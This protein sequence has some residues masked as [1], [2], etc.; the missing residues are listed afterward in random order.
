MTPVPPIGSNDEDRLDAK[1]EAHR[2]EIAD[3]VAAFKIDVH[4]RIDKRLG[5]GLVGAIVAFSG[6]AWSVCSQVDAEFT[7]PAV[8]T[9]IDRRLEE[10]VGEISE[11]LRII[12]ARERIARL[13]DRAFSDDD[14]EAYTELADF[15]DPD[16]IVQKAAKAAR[17]H[18]DL[19]LHSLVF[20]R[21]DE[22]KERVERVGSTDL[23]HTL[24]S[25][26]HAWDRVTASDLLA[27]WGQKRDDRAVGEALLE[28]A[29]KD[30]SITVRFFAVGDF[31]QRF[32]DRMEPHERTTNELKVLE[33]FL[34][35]VV[36]PQ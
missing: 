14:A 22:Q 30:P 21:I 20:R 4:D 18:V 25:G 19:Y 3:K 35:R 9:L 8:H 28:A 24:R 27:R 15:R 31:V 23:F 5:V 34:N 2:A 26:E 1:H 6:L 33:E 32:K 36:P 29:S 12:D 10:S 11:R 16:P 7:T 17:K 13:A